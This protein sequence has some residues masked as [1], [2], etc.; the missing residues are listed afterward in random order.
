M[1]IQIKKLSDLK[2]SRLLYEQNPPALGFYLIVTIT[3]AIMVAVA[4]SVIAQKTYVV[5][6]YG[7]VVS[8]S[9]NFIMS[10]YTGEIIESN[11]VA[12][13]YVEKE[14]VLFQI[15]STDLDLQAEQLEGAI[16]INQEKIAQYERLEECVKNGVNMFDENNEADKIYY[17]MY[18]T[19]LSQIE[20]K[21]IDLSAYRSYNYSDEQIAGVVI[22]NEAAIAEIYYST[23]RSIVDVIQNLETEIANYDVQLSAV[24]TG[25]SA[26]PVFASAS[27]IVHMDT[28]YKTGMVLQAGT[29][30]GTIVNENDAYYV[31]VY[32]SANDM[33]LIR[34]GDPVD[35]AISGLAQSVY[36]T[37]NGTVSYIASEATMDQESGS[38]AFMVKIDLDSV[39]LVSNKGNKIN[40]S[41]GMA[42]ETRIKYDE[43]TYFDYVLESLGLLTR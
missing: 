1:A 38:S 34:P 10:A 32:A 5:K 33:P 43:L 15:S 42:V 19:Y 37:I 20:Q 17:Y 36:G 14:D 2:D 11:I 16:L 31:M 4:W 7:S 6:C 35:I 23:L 26:Y 30:I 22:G 21:E 29:A 39:Y 9:R 40:L 8:V 3:V 41:N 12:G 25:K 28:E 24:Y 13:S 18:E 27:G